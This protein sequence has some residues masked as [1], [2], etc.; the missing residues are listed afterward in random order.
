M[1]V[2]PLDE[3]VYPEP[4][5][6]RPGSSSGLWRVLLLAIFFVA[7]AIGFSVMGERISAEWT[8]LFLG[9]LVVV[10]VFCLF[11]LAAGLF[12]LA[13]GEPARGLS[14]AIVDSLPY[15]AVVADREGRVVYANSAYGVMGSQLEGEPPVGVPRLFVSSPEASEAMYRLTRAAREGRA[16]QED[17]RLP[18]PLVAGARRGKGPTWYRVRVLGLPPVEGGRNLT[19]WS[20]EDISRDRDTQENIFLELQRAIDYLDHAPAGFFSADS[21]GRVQYL[22]ATLAD[23][24]G[25]DLA[26]FNAGSIRLSDI[27]RGDGAGLLLGGRRDGEIRTE[28]IDIDL[29]RRNGTSFPVRLLHRVARLA[30]G[31]LGET[32]TLVL[33]RSKGADTAEE[34]RAA[35]VRFSRFFNNTPFAIAALD[36]EARILRT[37]AP[38]M[39]TFGNEGGERA[40]EGLPLTELLAPEAGQRFME[41]IAEAAAN[42]SSIEP[43]DAVLSADGERS[44][45]LYLSSVEKAGDS[46]ETAIVFALDTTEQRQLE[47]QFAQ[48]QKMQ[49]IG[50]LAGGVAHDLNNVLTAII[51]FSDLLLINLRPADPTF[52]DIMQIKQNANRAAGLVRQLLAFS[53][54]Q[55]LRLEVLEIPELVDDLTVL[56]K[57]L[58]GET[59]VLGVDHSRDVWPVRA[60]RNQFEQVIINLV[61]NARDAMPG[62]GKVTVKTRNIGEREAAAF[63]YRGMPG[64]DYVLIEVEDSGTGMTPQVMEKIFEPFYTT[65]DIGKGTGLGLATVYGIIKQTGGFIYPESTVGKGT[66]FRIFL[67]RH[68]PA[69]GEATDRGGV[70]KVRD[71]TGD[72]RILIVED[73]ES[74]RAFSAR[75]LQSAGYTV[76]EAATGAE[77]LEVL[78]EIEGRIDL[79]ISD[80]VMPEMDGPEL[81]AHVRRNYPG[82]KVI[83]VSGYAEEGARKGLEE[84]TTVEFLPKPFSLNQLAA[85]VKSVLLD[86]PQEVKRPEAG[87]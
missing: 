72:E 58:I 28:I 47:Q 24:L 23:W 50:Q 84:D 42:R 35:E 44:V 48:S 54:R 76:H 22:N 25:Y 1:A 85:K 13:R 4:A 36:A 55:T 64:A 78:R 19:L 81:L 79:L 74:V 61:V 21:Q 17:I 8:L 60:D 26:E 7:V 9:T 3:E 63:N 52:K 62:G 34:L 29:V 2:S 83:F 69:E 57:R 80:V 18:G 39:R 43:V 68:V 33:D 14:S 77:A 32:R 11:A 12:K 20:V 66:T 53:R 6:D 38:F 87:E 86:E 27:V 73:E 10:G 75:A 45:R 59:I 15:G 49:A 31:D 51:G 30:E 37:N 71:L 67:P 40:T 82:V 16:A 5:V 41:A 70:A 56:L 65:K 46:P